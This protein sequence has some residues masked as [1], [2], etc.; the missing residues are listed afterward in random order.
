M[1][2]QDLPEVEI[3]PSAEETNTE[4]TCPYCQF[5]FE[6]DRCENHSHQS[7]QSKRMEAGGGNYG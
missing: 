3:E 4:R 2:H 5:P 1:N 6:G 7:W